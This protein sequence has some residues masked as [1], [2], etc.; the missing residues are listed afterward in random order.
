ML[1]LFWRQHLYFLLHKDYFLL[2][3]SFPPLFFK[4]DILIVP[5]R[6]GLFLFLCSVRDAFVFPVCWQGGLQVC[7]SHWPGQECGTCPVVLLGG[8]RYCFGLE[9]FQVLWPFPGLFLEMVPV[10]V[11]FATAEKEMGAGL[12][13]GEVNSF[14][15]SLSSSERHT[16][17]GPLPPLGCEQGIFGQ[18]G[19]RGRAG[20]E[21]TDSGEGL[22]SV[23][24]GP[25]G[26]NP[27]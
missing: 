6:P 17:T 11:E 1:L 20:P 25:V 24:S 5:S 13:R 15:P 8:S 26:L 18:C 10:L 2:K 7:R 22:S 3:S 14:N 16:L 21:P 19:C 9:V 12:S 4:R 27:S 23:P